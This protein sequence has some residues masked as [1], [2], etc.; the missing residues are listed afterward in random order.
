MGLCKCP[1][2]KVTNLFCFE[3][4]VNVCEH[5]LV[6]NHP[7]CIVKSYL[8]WLQ[9]SDYDTN[10]TLCGQTLASEEVV[11]LTCHDVFHWSC[12][13]DFAKELPSNTA[14]AGYTCPVCNE[15]VFPK[16]NM[17]SPVIEAL[18][19]YLTQADWARAGLGLPA[20]EESVRSHD[21]MYKNQQCVYQVCDDS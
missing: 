5:C 18:K 17:V 15:C 11:R 12:L 7:R 2:R 21:K 8:H 16:S 6:A 10:C 19:E 4:R 14:P 20:F 3:H 1:K 9:D 13:D